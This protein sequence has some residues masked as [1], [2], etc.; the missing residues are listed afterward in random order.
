MRLTTAL[1]PAGILSGSLNS[2]SCS[3]VNNNCFSSIFEGNGKRIS[4]LQIN[5]DNASYAGL[6]AGNSGS[7]RNIR[8]A[9]PKVDSERIIGGF[10]RFQ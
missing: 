6:F 1:T 5:R 10:G 2:R 7:I 8:L 4:N 9:E 3:N